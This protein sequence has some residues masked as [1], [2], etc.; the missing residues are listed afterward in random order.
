[1]SDFT[2]STVPGCRTPHFWLAA[3][4]SLYDAMGANFALLRFDRSIDVS[5]LMFAMRDRGMSIRVVDIDPN[6]APDCYTTKLVLS[7]PD[8]HVAW[9]RDAIPDDVEKIVD[10]LCGAKNELRRLG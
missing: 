7:R 9:R 5:V 8:Q 4:K 10:R 3:G 2:P 1:M 6:D